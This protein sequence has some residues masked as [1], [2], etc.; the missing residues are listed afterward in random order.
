MQSVVERRGQLQQFYR[1]VGTTNYANEQTDNTE[2]VAERTVHFT[3]PNESTV[4]TELGDRYDADMVGLT[5]VKDSEFVE[6]APIQDSISIQRND[7]T[8]YGGYTY[9]VKRIQ[10]EPRDSDAELAKLYLVKETN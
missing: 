5:V 10:T 6:N 9:K 3:S 4:G 7:L 2:Q 8:D 1:N